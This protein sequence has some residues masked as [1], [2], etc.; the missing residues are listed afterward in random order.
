MALVKSLDFSELYFIYK[1]GY[2]DSPLRDAVGI[3]GKTI[4]RVPS[5]VPE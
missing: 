5:S 2:S 3:E 4:S 1:M